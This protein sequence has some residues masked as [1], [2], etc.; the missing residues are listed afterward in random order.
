MIWN[1]LVYWLGGMI[2]LITAIFPSAD[3]N[4]I[5]LINTAQNTFRTYTQSI[6]W[7][8]PV[9]TFFQVVTVILTIE[10]T[11]LTINVGLYI[12]NFIS[13]RLIPR[14]KS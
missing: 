9:N 4:I 7:I 3:Q 14:L 10:I 1:I 6:S 8:F 11:L 2:T 12:L 13:M 5:S